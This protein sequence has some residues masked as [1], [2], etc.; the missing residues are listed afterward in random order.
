MWFLTSCR[1]QL[2][3]C[4]GGDDRSFVLHQDP[5]KMQKQVLVLNETQIYVSMH[6]HKKVHYTRQGDGTK[7]HGDCIVKHENKKTRKQPGTQNT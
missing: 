1:F 6:T 2:R 5:V 3:Y 4:A 7:I